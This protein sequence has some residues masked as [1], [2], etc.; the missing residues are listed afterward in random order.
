VTFRF[1]IPPR[2][3]WLGRFRFELSPAIAHPFASSGGVTETYHVRL[4][5]HHPQSPCRTEAIGETRAFR[6][7]PSRPVRPTPSFRRQTHFVD[8]RKFVRPDASPEVLVPFSVH[9]LR[10]A[11]RGGRP[12]DNPASTFHPP[13]RPVRTYLLMIRPC[14]FP[15]H[16]SNA[17]MLVVADVRFRSFQWL[18]RHISPGGQW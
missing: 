6:A 7:I 15:L 4:G 12:P 5:V 1:P 13:A 14:G 9:W 16:E 3:H 11:I 17:V 18:A 8:W 2:L 10:R